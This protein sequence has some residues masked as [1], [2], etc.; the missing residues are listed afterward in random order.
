MRESV[1]REDRASK[2]N[3]RLTATTVEASEARIQE[4]ANVGGKERGRKETTREKAT[5][6]WRARSTKATP[7]HRRP[8]LDDR[9]H[10][11]LT[12]V[13]P[14]SE[15]A[16]MRIRHAAVPAYNCISF[17]VYVGLCWIKAGRHRRFC[18]PL[19]RDRARNFPDAFASS[20]PIRRRLLLF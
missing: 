20:L 19:L 18:W 15:A 1:E 5:W 8:R 17:Q 2:K 12:S 3:A 13:Q 6:T 16:R 14:F 10:Q 9:I 7:V 4:S 11:L